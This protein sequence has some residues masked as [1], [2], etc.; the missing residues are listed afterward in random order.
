MNIKKQI[1]NFITLLN[2]LAGIIAV[3][4]AVEGK[5][6]LA[7]IFVLIGIFFD[8]FDGL[9]ARLL[10]AQSELGKQLDSLADMV[11]SG[12]VPGIILYQLLKDTS[13]IWNEKALLATSFFTEGFSFLPL[14]GLVFSL[15]A[16]YR[17][18]NFNI[19]ERQ[20]SSFIGL[21]TPAA[22]LFVISLPFI[23]HYSSSDMAVDLI[24]NKWF[25]IGI[26]ILLSYLMNAN[27]PLFA[28]KLKDLSWKNNG[29]IYIFLLLSLVLLITL[30]FVAVP[31]I[32]VIYILFSVVKKPK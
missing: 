4:L 22:T 20:T 31:V 17:L 3:M 1:P 27:L 29:I 5:L 11:T 7:G 6:M 15:A 25:L 2:L 32:I 28:L 9:V 18:A 8:F 23:M 14:I 24:L 19:D 21:P 30:K 12:V 16:A 10:K 26:T 13:G